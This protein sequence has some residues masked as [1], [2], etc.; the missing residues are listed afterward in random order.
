[1]RLAAALSLAAVFAGCANA[2]DLEA[3]GQDQ[4]KYIAVGELPPHRQ[5]DFWVGDWDVNN[6]QKDGQG[7]WQPV[8][9]SVAKIRLAAGGNC[10]IEDWRGQL[11][12]NKLVGYSIR[13]Y[14]ENQ[15]QWFIFLNWHGGNPGSRGLMAGRAKTDR[16]EFTPPGG[17]TP[18]YTFSKATADS[19]QWDEAT[20]TDQGETYTT[21]WIMDFQRTGPE[22]SLTAENLP[23]EQPLE[24]NLKRFTAYRSFDELIGR[25][26]GEASAGDRTGTVKISTTSTVEG[27][28]LLMIM[29]IAWSDGETESHVWTFAHSQQF[30]SWEILRVDSTD[31]E[32]FSAIGQ[33]DGD[34]GVFNERVADSEP[35]RRTNWK[36]LTPESLSFA[37]E[38]PQDGGWSEVLSVSA[39][40]ADR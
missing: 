34:Q 29:D 39:T 19:C 8:G 24:S 38:L 18:R 14:D 31:S 5:F 20:S 9:E 27:F 33:F 13:A 3:A 1:M 2:P 7:A 40:K 6:R 35:D 30:Q 22:K 36:S 17:V 10:V 26:E 11:N 23:I 16:L 21:N 25:W 32:F 4:D 15:K 12:G 28:G 37:I